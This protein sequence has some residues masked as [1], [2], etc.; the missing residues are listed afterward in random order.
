MNGK[1]E[2]RRPEKKWERDQRFNKPVTEV[3]RF[4]MGRVTFPKCGSG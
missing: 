4:A 2:K 1:R 3:G